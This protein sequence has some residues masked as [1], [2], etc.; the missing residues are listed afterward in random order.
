MPTW[1]ITLPNPESSGYNL[2]P[3]DQVMRTEMEMGSPRVRRRTAAS[4]DRVTL[5]WQ[6]TDAQLNILRS[7]FNDSATGI[8]G[9][10]AWF[11]ISLPVGGSSLYSTVEARFVGVFQSAREDTLWR[12]SAT[13]ETR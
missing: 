1:P 11:T 10:S 9:G 13:L 3:V 12:V 5:N 7:W 8:S 6:M 2:Q 4:N